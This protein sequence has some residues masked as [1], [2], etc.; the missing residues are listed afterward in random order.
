M[1]DN[2]KP[3]PKTTKHLPPRGHALFDMSHPIH[4]VI[5]IHLSPSSPHPTSFRVYK[6]RTTSDG[7]TS[8]TQLHFKPKKD[9]K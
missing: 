4:R 1:K 2:T 8:F 5:S 6:K 9:K 7:D 3:T